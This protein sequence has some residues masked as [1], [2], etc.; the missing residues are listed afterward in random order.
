MPHHKKKMLLLVDDDQDQLALGTVILEVSGYNVLTATGAAEALSLFASNP[1]SAVILDYELAKM[2]GDLVA[3][4]MKEAKPGIP[5][6]MFSGC[7]LLPESALSHVD[8]YLPK[9]CETELLLRRI[10][11]LLLRV[12]KRKPQRAAIRERWKKAVAGGAGD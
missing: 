10:R 7:L 6:L 1:V 4:K 2:N 9:P 5:I 3:I 12:H 8:A 11:Q